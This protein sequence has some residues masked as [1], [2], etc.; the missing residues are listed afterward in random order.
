MPL[1]RVAF[2]LTVVAVGCGPA[3][4]PGEAP[5][6]DAGRDAGPPALDSG[7]VVPDAGTPVPDAGTA[8]V[9]DAGLPPVVDAGIP[10][11]QSPDLPCSDALDSVYV[12]PAFTPNLPDSAR[13]QPVRC[14]IE[15]TLTLADVRAKLAT[16][17]SAVTTY[18]ISYRTKRGDGS[19]AIS[20]GRVFLPQTPLAY[21]LPIIVVAHPS[22]GVADNC[23]PS[24]EQEG[25][26]GLALPWAAKGYAV[27]A[28]DF[29]G[30]G[31]DGIQSY[32][33]NR[34]TGHSTLDAARALRFLH[35]PATFSEKIAML[36]YSQGGG[37]VFAAQ[38]LEHLY[39]SGGKLTAVVAF[40]PQW[41]SRLD[42]FGTVTLLRKPTAL[43]ISTGYTKPVIAAMRQYG[44]AATYLGPA[45]AGEPFASGDR[46]AMLN[47]LDTMCLI[48]FGGWVQ[49]THTMLGSLTDDAF[50][51]S[52]LACLDTPTDPACKEPGKGYA[53]YLKDNVIAPDPAGSPVLYVQGVLDTVMP[54]GE[55][56]ACNV[57]KLQQAGVDLT[58]CTDSGA[59]HANIVDR[60]L[61]FALRWAEA[62]LSGTQPPTCGAP[63]QLTP[64]PP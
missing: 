42:S 15:K 43:T 37:A 22:V 9:P 10:N 35:T 33:D 47:A 19:W 48:G 3:S 4:V 46:T 52:T 61:D 54:F 53:Q 40:A 57:P 11:A 51:T 7:V 13:G 18:K 24:K 44:W 26:Y 23:A 28:P 64:C 17:A 32:V 36:G 63:A 41:Q 14:A 58:F 55:E 6:A 50:R 34:D 31:T 12:S 62:K 56:A 49:G 5:T 2:L 27:I 38:S 45:R 25:T 59:G 60:Q 16:A 30:L 39:G 1:R 20:S 21:P 8:A 29:A